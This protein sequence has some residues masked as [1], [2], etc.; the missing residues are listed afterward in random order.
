MQSKQRL[1]ELHVSSVR[2]NYQ[3]SWKKTQFD[4]IRRGPLLLG[5][6]CSRSQ[7]YHTSLQ[8]KVQNMYKPYTECLWCTLDEKFLER[9]D[10]GFVYVSQNGE[11]LLRGR[12]QANALWVY[13][14]EMEKRAAGGHGKYG[15]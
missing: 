1:C 13:Q 10:A 11:M 2:V 7:S 14:D 12:F 6:A 3:I 15:I 5:R 4:P 9:W 8:E